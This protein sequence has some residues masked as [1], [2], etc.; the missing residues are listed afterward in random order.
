MSVLHVAFRVAGAQYVLPASAVL[1]LE[2][3]DGA[4]RVPGTPEFIAGLV[5]TRG[6]MV[7]VVD[8]RAR[9]G[10]PGVERT[11]DTRVLIVKVGERTVG[12]LVD[13]A[14]EVLD[15]EEGAFHAPPDLIGEQSMGLVEAVA[16]ADERMVMLIDLPKVIGE[17]AHAQ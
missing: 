13:S 3:F 1:H 8:L 15:I 4:T 7:P 2:S 6:Q 14:R 17:G 11:L 10:L 12:L 5:H 16:Q 9:F